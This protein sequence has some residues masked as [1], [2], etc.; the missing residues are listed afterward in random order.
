V[1]DRRP[2]AAD[3][4]TGAGRYGDVKAAWVQLKQLADEGHKDPETLG[5]L[6]RTYKSIGAA[7]DSAQDRERN[8][9]EALELYQAG[10]NQ[11]QDPWLGINAALLAMLLGDEAV[12]FSFAGEVRRTC[13]G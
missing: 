6:G 5:L 12:A 4:G 13:R 1:A 10:Y 3:V 11:C 9:E 7:A 8:Y 2:A